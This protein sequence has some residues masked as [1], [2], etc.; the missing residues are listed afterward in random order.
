MARGDGLAEQRRPDA[1]DVGIGKEA[2]E[3]VGH[4][5]LGLGPAE[6]QEQNR[7]PRSRV[8][9]VRENTGFSADWPR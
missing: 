9:S 4:V 2:I 7:P 6:L 8:Y 3:K 1:D 5:L